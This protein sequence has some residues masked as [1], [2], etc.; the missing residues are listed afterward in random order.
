VS[1]G[2]LQA[3]KPKVDAIRFAPL[4]NEIINALREEDLINNR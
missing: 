1:D 4:W 3:P 2:V